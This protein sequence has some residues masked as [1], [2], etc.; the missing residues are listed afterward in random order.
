[1][2]EPLRL[3]S[4]R[5]LPQALTK[6]AAAV[7]LGVRIAR[8]KEDIHTLQ[9]LAI[10]ESVRG[11]VFSAAEL[12][13]QARVDGDLRYVLRD[14]V[15]PRQVGRCL[16]Q[17]AARPGHGVRLVKIDRNEA[18]CIWGIELQADAGLPP[19]AGA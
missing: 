4:R 16:V 13:A 15:T 10:A 2:V 18:G 17:L 1:M 3:V 19:D 11:C 9:L 6:P 14:A 5:V 7:P 8:L 12:L